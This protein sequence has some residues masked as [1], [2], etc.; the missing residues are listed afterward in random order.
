MV[1]ALIQ[2]ERAE[3][4]DSAFA[5]PSLRIAMM[6]DFVRKPGESIEEV[7][8]RWERSLRRAKRL[9]AGLSRRD[10]AALT[11]ALVNAGLDTV[12]TGAALLEASRR[13]ATLAPDDPEAVQWYAS[14]LWMAGAITSEPGWR[15]KFHAARETAWELDSLT[16]A[17]ILDSAYWGAL[18]TGDRDWAAHIAPALAGRVDSTAERWY[19]TQWALAHLL[20]DSAIVRDIRARA[21]QGDPLVVGF[22]TLLAVGEPATR[23]FIPMHDAVLITDRIGEPQTSLWFAWLAVGK[24]A[25]AA[26]VLSQYELVDYAYAFPGLDSAAA[27]AADTLLAWYA[28]RPRESIGAWQGGFVPY[29]S[30]EHR[31][32][33]L[34]AR[35]QWGDTVG[36]R[37]RAEQLV[38]EYRA[39]HR[40]PICPAKVQALVESHDSV[41]SDTPALDRFEALMRAGSGS[42]VVAVTGMLVVARLARERGQLERALQ[43]AG[44]GCCFGLSLSRTAQ[45]PLLK[46][47]GELAAILGDTA[48]AIDAFTRYLNIRVDPDPGVVQAEVDSV[49]AALA[50]LQR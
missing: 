16:P 39:A 48:R 30:G 3:V 12:E 19:G 50:A 38:P 32:Y 2:F 9:R 8:S 35:A 45:A 4:L 24:M 21:E 44:D 31:C 37:A 28:E 42:E 17:R 47:E 20:G 23:G 11:F 14:N 26:A 13:W 7:W 36:V 27:V 40:L 22:P 46:E 49:R 1:E 10:D 6:V 41:R 33:A 43:A 5:L 25:A 18:Y 15:E 34:L 29:R